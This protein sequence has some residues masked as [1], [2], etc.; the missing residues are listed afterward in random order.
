VL[1]FVDMAEIHLSSRLLE[2]ENE[3]QDFKF[4][5][6]DSRKLA[7]TISAFSNAAGGSVFIGVKDNGK[8]KGI[9]PEEEGFM[10]DAAV[11]MYCKPAVD[12]KLKV[13]E[14]LEGRV[15]EVLV[16][17]SERKPVYAKTEHGEWRAFY[18]VNDI[19]HLAPW[20]LT[21][22][23]KLRQSISPVEYRH[24]PREGLIFSAFHES[25]TL[26]QKQL[27]KKTRIPRPALIRLMGKLLCWNVILLHWGTTGPL[28]SLNPESPIPGST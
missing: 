21:E 23:W 8:I 9:D 3:H 14:T 20:I 27:E 10:V 7:E 13:W 25:G 4:C 16:P 17:V 26:S 19:N 1:I 24:T 15:L 2:G 11:S 28:Y 18:R 5:I 6:T 22:C 12:C